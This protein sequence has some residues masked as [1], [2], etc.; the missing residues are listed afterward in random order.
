MEANREQESQTTQELTTGGNGSFEK[1]TFTC[2]IF[3]HIYQDDTDEESSDLSKELTPNCLG[4]NKNDTDV[5]QS[6]KFRI[7][8]NHE[9]ESVK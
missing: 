4:I 8:I 6:S 3:A 1:D 9:F 2:S 5:E 7:G